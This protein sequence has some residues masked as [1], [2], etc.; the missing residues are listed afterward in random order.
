[1][2]AIQVSWLRN[3]ACSKWFIEKVLGKCSNPRQVKVITDGAGWYPWACK[4][5]KVKHEKVCGGKRNYIERFYRTF[6]NWA[7][8]FHKN[9]TVKAF[10]QIEAVE[11]KIGLWTGFTTTG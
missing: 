2:L 7:I 10:K 8:K 1:M 4:L 9:F 5:L 11:S 3:G 6:K